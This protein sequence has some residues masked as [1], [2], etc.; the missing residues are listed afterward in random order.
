MI[1]SNMHNKLTTIKKV[2]WVI[3]PFLLLTILIIL[4]FRGCETKR[5]EGKD[6]VVDGVIVKQPTN[7]CRAH[8]S[9]LLMNDSYLHDHNSLIFITDEYSEY[10]GEGN[11]PRAKLAFPRA[12]ETTFDGIAIDK[13][14]RIII[15]KEENFKGDI[16][17]DVNGPAIIN[18][19]K[20]EGDSSLDNINNRTLKSKLEGIFPKNCRKF[21]KSNMHTWSNGSLKVICNE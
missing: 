1:K 17:L 13:K 10:V 18:N 5:V 20:W 9:G 15:Y 8:F 19:V 6:I 2:I 16:L 4:L 11:Y 14:T 12:H 7:N 21:S 3:T